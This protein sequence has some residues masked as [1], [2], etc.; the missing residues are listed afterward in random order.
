ML[1]QMH[2]LTAAGH[3]TTSNT[4]TWLFYELAQHPQFQ[5]RIRT[6]IRAARAIV[7]ERGDRAFS[8]EDLDGM[9]VTLATIKVSHATTRLLALLILRPDSP[10]NTSLPSYCV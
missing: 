2:T 10:G 1:A 5:A 6:E 3:E 9:K 8:L 4:L 7:I